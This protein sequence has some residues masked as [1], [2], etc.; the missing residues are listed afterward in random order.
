M[1]ARAVAST[2]ASRAVQPAS[3]GSED[4]PLAVWPAPSSDLAFRSCTSVASGPGS[5]W[6]CV[7]HSPSI[8]GS[9]PGGACAPSSRCP[10]G[11]ARRR[12]SAPGETVFRVEAVDGADS[13]DLLVV[14]VALQEG[15]GPGEM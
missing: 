7:C 8:H 13:G 6:P 2:R 3:C 1:T 5:S 12:S 11:V 14:E 9:F 4:V 10:E 15:C